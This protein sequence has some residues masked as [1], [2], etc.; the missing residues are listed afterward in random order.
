MEV[1]LCPGA[2]ACAECGGRLH[3]IWECHPRAR[4]G[5]GRFIVNLILTASPTASQM[6]CPTGSG[7]CSARPTRGGR[8]Q[9]ICNIVHN[10]L[11]FGYKFGRPTK[12]AADAWREGSGIC[13]DFA[14]IPIALCWR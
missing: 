1:E 9:A 14:H 12:T 8:I 6:L 5:P 2:D 7:S 11:T 4:Y 13:R 3:P 10:H